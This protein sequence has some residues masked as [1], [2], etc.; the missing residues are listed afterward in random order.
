MDYF[1]LNQIYWNQQ[2]QRVAD[3]I[4]KLEGRKTAV[5]NG[6]E[7]PED[8]DLPIGTGRRL[9]ATILFID[10]CNFSSRESN[11]EEEQEAILWMLNLFFAE[12]I[13]IIEDYGGNVE[14]N[15]GDGLLA[16]FPDEATD[17][18]KSCHRALAAV[19][20]MKTA[21]ANLINPVCVSK[22][23]PPI[24]FRS[25][26]D[27]GDITVAQIGAPRRFNSMVAIGA[28]ANLASK[29]MKFAGAGQ[30]IVG[31]FAA[32]LAPSDW[33]RYFSLVETNSGWVV[34]GTPSTKRPYKLYM[35]NCYWDL[36][37]W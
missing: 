1:T 19:L 5:R 2:K 28:T 37:G 35:F 18:G 15:T 33:Q 21:T 7:I 30:I 24:E 11:S 29:V 27:F 3:L 14:K 26:I 8:G 22:S 31:E 23:L 4:A 36:T 12:M 25:S 9:L 32:I 34:G 20:T 17:R 13:R 6:R 10:I 16:Y